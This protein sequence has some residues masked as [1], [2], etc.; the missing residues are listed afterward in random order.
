MIKELEEKNKKQKIL[1]EL[2]NRAEQ[3]ERLVNSY[4]N[5]KSLYGQLI[6]TLN[7]GFYGKNLTELKNYFKEKNIRINGSSVKDNFDITHLEMQRDLIIK[8]GKGILNNGAPTKEDFF[9]IANNSAN[10]GRLYFIA[11]YGEEPLEN[12]ENIQE[13]QLSIENPTVHQAETKEK[14][15]L[16]KEKSNYLGKGKTVKKEEK[17]KTLEEL[18]TALNNLAN[19]LSNIGNVR[20]PGGLSHCLYEDLIVKVYKTK[21]I[22]KIKDLT[23]KLN[24]QLNANIINI[25][26]VM[27]EN[28]LKTI[29]ESIDLLTKY[30]N[31]K[32]LNQIKTG[33]IYDY[34]KSVSTRAYDSIKKKSKENNQEKSKMTPYKELKSNVRKLK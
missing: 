4:Q 24:D 26:D 17:N 3:V 7:K 28:H 5:D 16:K 1:E 25:E 11:T 2:K 10:A 9:R 6:G 19:A 13:I 23:T 33:D 21:D 15:S 30:V 8:L 27:P 18:N 29:T 22:K 14:I 34:N 12:L 20:N 32:N 31:N